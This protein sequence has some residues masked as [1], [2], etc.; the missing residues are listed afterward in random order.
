MYKYFFVLLAFLVI[1]CQS[2]SGMPDLDLLK[3]GL[4]IKIKAPEGASVKVNDMGIAKDVSVTSGTDFYIQILNSNA[5]DYDAKNLKIQEL[6]SLQKKDYFSKLIQ[7][8]D[9]GFIFEKQFGEDKL[10]YDFRY[11]K[12]QGDQEYKFQ[13]GLIGDYTEEDVRNMY[14]AV[15]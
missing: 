13:V 7:E 8:D 2:E 11:F 15:K 12:I 3:H 1:G 10:N 14:E 5:V 6:A 4:G 9:Y